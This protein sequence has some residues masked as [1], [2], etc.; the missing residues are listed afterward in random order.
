[1]SEST[2]NAPN[3]VRGAFGAVAGCV[4]GVLGF[5]LLLRLGL[6]GMVLPGAVVGWACGA[7]SG[8]RSVP[9]G[10]LSAILATG[11]CLYAEWHFFPFVADNS[12]AYFLSHL[13]DL[14]LGTTLSMSASVFAGFWFGAGR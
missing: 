7:Q 4:L 12:F 6:Y 9:L 11:T 5:G 13:T 2:G 1:M 14:Q 8:G 3:L 10:I